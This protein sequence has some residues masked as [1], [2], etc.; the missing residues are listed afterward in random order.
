MN[1]TITFSTRDFYLQHFPGIFRE[2]EYLMS[3]LS[4]IEGCR[5]LLYCHSFLLL[6]II[7]LGKRNTNRRASHLAKRV[8][9]E[10][11]KTKK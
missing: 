3:E 10:E 11:V 6:F 4:N 8:R 7:Q 5:L 1:I 9:V 2:S